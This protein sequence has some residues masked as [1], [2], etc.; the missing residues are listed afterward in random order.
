MEELNN[1]YS[2]EITISCIPSEIDQGKFIIEYNKCLLNSYKVAQVY[3]NVEIVE[4]IILM[5][6]IDG[7]GKI[8][9]HAWNLQEGIYFDI[10]MEVLLSNH[11]EMKNIKEIK[12][13][14]AIKY[15]ISDFENTQV[16]EFSPM[17]L[18]V[19]GDLNKKI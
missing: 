19:V 2:T 11:P 16:I 18:G 14:P 5:K 17:T 6:S 10:T 9:A 13:F 12:Y 8:I 15:A 4:G 7:N 1:A 3:P